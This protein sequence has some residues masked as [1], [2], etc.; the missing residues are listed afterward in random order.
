MSTS[1]IERVAAIYNEIAPTWDR[2]QG[3]AERTLMGQ[4]MRE[5]LASLLQGEVLEIGTGT[6]PTLRLLADTDR[7]TAFTGLDFSEGMLAEARPHADHLPF[8]VELLPGNAETLPFADDS[9]DTVTTSLTLCTVPDPARALREMARVCRP[10]GRVVILEHVRARNPILAAMQRA[11]TPLQVRMLGCHF[12][13]PTHRLVRDLGFT[14][15]AERT[16]FFGIFR[17]LAMRPPTT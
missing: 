17:L 10:E 8:P 13:R 12:D 5:A 11:L 14:V 2:R 4:G 9:F 16:R 15:E 1:E 6:G 3:I 7:V